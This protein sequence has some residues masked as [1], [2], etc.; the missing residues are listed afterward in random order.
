MGRAALVVLLLAAVACGSDDPEVSDD[1]EQQVTELEQDV[2]DLGEQ[3]D[4]VEAQRQA[5][6]AAEFQRCYH[7]PDTETTT[8]GLPDCP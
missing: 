1:L 7:D 8:F 3:L 5:E 4:Q 2:E 6:D